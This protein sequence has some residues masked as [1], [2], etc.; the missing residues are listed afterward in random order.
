MPADF[1]EKFYSQTFG[2]LSLSQV[3]EK[4]AEFMGAS[5]DH[6]YRIVIG[7]D[8]QTKNHGEESDFV[9]A[10]IIHRIGA[11]GI[12]F[13]SRE[14][15]QKRYDLR[16]RIYEE[17]AVAL[18]LAHKFIEESHKNG[19]WGYDFEIH[20]DIGMVGETREM[21]AEVV[22]MIRGS[23]FKVKTKPD[24]YAASKVADRHT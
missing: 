21:I 12:Y 15:R 1:L 16:R 22:G 3:R 14:R 19:L 4:I 2:E 7:V 24:S 8:S 18:E 17:A 5:P 9:A 20:V 13:W 10:I 11:G 6:S 23:G